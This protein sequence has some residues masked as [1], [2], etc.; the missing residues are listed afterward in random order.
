MIR[1]YLHEYT[2]TVLSTWF[3]FPKKNLKLYFF[4]E[5]MQFIAS[6][7]NWTSNWTWNLLFAA[8]FFYSFEFFF[9]VVQ[10][11]YVH[12]YGMYTIGIRYNVVHTPECRLTYFVIMLRFFVLCCSIKINNCVTSLFFK[13]ISFILIHIIN[14]PRCYIHTNMGHSMA[15]SVTFTT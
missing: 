5:K 7:L 10:I 3:S 12:I 9:V 15:A 11:L 8:C 1:H 14:I 6:N 13:C 4:S 2:L